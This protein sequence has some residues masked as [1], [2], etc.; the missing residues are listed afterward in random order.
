MQ[1][2]IA[3]TAVQQRTLTPVELA[4][5]VRMFRESK[6]WSQEQ[7]AEISKLS[8]RTVQR[9]EEGLPSSVNTRRAIASA[10]GFE[11]IDALNKPHAIP[12]P[13]QVAERQ[14]R[15]DREHLTVHLS[16]RGVGPE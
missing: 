12:S 13:G 10:M 5:L 11:D 2:T 14:A 15:F 1:S 7:L 9:V 6:G 8:S 16:G 4:A 3:E